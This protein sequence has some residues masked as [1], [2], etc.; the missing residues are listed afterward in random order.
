[1]F[2]RVNDMCA[3]CHDIDNDPHYKFET[4]WPQIIHGRN[5]PK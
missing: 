4:Y 1:M 2:N 3:K 5:A